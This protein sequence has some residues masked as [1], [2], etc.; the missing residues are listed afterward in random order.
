MCNNIP[1]HAPIR[2]NIKLWNKTARECYENNCNCEK[3][4]IFKTYFEESDEI[5]H[6]KYYVK[7]LLEKIGKP[8]YF[9]CG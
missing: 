5:C 9:K 2:E 3:C 8:V 4:F 1:H 6:M 7:T